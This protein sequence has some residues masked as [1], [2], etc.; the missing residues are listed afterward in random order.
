M[1]LSPSACRRVAWLNVSGWCLLT[2]LQRTPAFRVGQALT[3]QVMRSPA[4]SLLR[5]AVA[6]VTGLGAIQTLAGATQFIQSPDNPIAGTVG[7][8]V[9]AAF[10]YVGTPSSPARFL[11]V[12]GELPP[13]LRF[14]PEPDSG[15]NIRS[16]APGITGT[17]TQAGSFSVFV[18]GF[19]AEG[20]TNGEQ[21]M[22]SFE[23]TGGTTTAAPTI[24]A[25]PASVSGTEG[26]ALQ[27]SVEATGSPSPAFQWRRNGVPI[28]NATSAV[29]QLP[30]LASGDCGIYSVDVI[31]SSGTVRSRSAIV[32]LTS[33]AKVVGS[34]SQVAENIVFSNGNIFDQVLLGVGGAATVNPDDG[35]I[36]RISYVD[37]NDDIVQ[38]EFSG[39]GS[40]TLVLDG[41]SGPAIPAKYDQQVQY[42]KGH[43]G[44]IVTGADATTNMSVFSVGR[45]NAVNQSLFS[46]AITYDG[47]ADIAFVAITSADGKF[48]GMRTANASYFAEQGL[49]GVYAPGVEFG[50][51]FVSDIDARGSATP[52]IRLGA[53]AI[54]RIT[55]G[56]LQQSNGSAVDVSG[57]SQLVFA[58]GSSSHGVLFEAQSNLGRLE[59]E[60]V[61]R[62]SQLVVNPAP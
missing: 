14:D 42:M 34:G 24:T 17:P 54:T 58:A 37:L 3:Q 19:N 56:N 22:I 28:A 10:T 33:A 12:G 1:N 50:V 39:A 49:T 31:N 62:T 5:A 61:D 41:K 13:G 46:D 21:Q 32:G 26:A 4:S 43:A 48:A 8:G 47:F 9:Q 27:L 16:G 11:V 29:F 25:H 40:L 51:V 60:G 44:I 6:A 36:V 35:E 2:L 57:L 18:Q 52:V 38:V 23:I 20:L 30:S 53:T 15:G 59:E 7:A 55:G 45:A